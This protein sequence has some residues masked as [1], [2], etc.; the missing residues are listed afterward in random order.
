[1]R[2][3]L[4]VL[5]LLSITPALA[6]EP[7]SFTIYF[8]L[9]SAR[10]SEAARKI[11]ERA[12]D[13]AK[14]REA[15]NRFDHIKVVGYADTSGSDA[16]AQVLSQERAEA[17]KQLLLARGLPATK[18]KTEGR[19]KHDLAVATRNHV[20]DARNRRARIVIYAPGE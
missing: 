10:P 5:A 18:V 14:Q 9:N 1:M 19:G 15:E 2:I 8:D 6:Q 20:R 7:P 11:V 12:A 13:V 16:R 4:M 3:A 17:V